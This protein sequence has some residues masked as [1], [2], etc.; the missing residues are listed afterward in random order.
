[1]KV[2]LDLTSSAFDGDRKSRMDQIFD[3]AILSLQTSDVFDFFS[4]D[5]L[6]EVA[7]TSKTTPVGLK[8]EA[9]ILED[10]GL[11]HKAFSKFLYLADANKLLCEPHKIMRKKTLDY[12]IRVS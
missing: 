3:E 1:M 8:L 11:A 12:F 6:A 4:K 7:V 10:Y 5:D 2:P 9:S